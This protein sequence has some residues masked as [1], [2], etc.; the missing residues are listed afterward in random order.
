MIMAM[1]CSARRK[2]GQAMSDVETKAPKTFTPDAI[3]MVRTLQNINVT[4]SQMADQKASILMGATFVV[5]S[6]SIGQ[7]SRPGGLSLSIAVL[8]LFALIAAVLAVLAI[9]PSVA[10]KPSPNLL[11]FGSFTQLAE[12][13]FA[14]QVIAKLETAESTYR[15]MLHDIYQ[16]GQVLQ[17]KKY[18]FLGY[19]Y[20]VFLLGL[21]LTVITFVAEK[22]LWIGV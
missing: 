22:M 10:A 6:I 8:A 16:N 17:H 14:D 15:M 13:D 5:F 3:H 21:V 12:E 11:F 18:R 2:K 19:A 20:R 4:L 1:A 7:A 9:I